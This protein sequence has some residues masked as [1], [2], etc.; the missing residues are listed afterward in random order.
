MT[1]HSIFALLLPLALPAAAAPPELDSLRQQYAKVV[2]EPHEKGLAELDAKFTTALDNAVTTAKQAGRLDDVLALQQDQ[3]RIADKLPLPDDE[4]TTPEVVK[5]LRVIYREQSAKL[6]ARREAAHAEVLPAYVAKLQELEATLTK[7]DRV[8]DALQVKLHRESLA[9]GLAPV[10][11]PP[12]AA[13]TTTPAPVAPSL[14]VPK[15]KGDDRK[16]AE[17]V[18]SVGGGV[19][20]WES[21]S[22]SRVITT[23]ADLPTGKLSLRVVRL[24]NIKGGIQPVSDADLLVLAGLE[25]LERVVWVKLPITPAAFDVLST[26]PQLADIQ[27]QYNR[28]GDELWTHLAGVGKLK[29]FWQNYDGLPVQGIG[30]S[31]LGREVESLN[32]SSTAV[33]DAALV[34]IGG[35]AGMKQLYLAETKITDAGLPALAQLKNLHMLHVMDTDVTAAGL[36]SLKGLP[37]VTLGYGRHMD[38]LAAQVP[39][40]AAL[41]PKLEQ[42]VVPRDSNPT[43]EHWNAVAAALPRLKAIYLRSFKFSDSASEGL[44]LLPDLEKLD[45]MYAPL[46]DV[47]VAHLALLEK[48]NWLSIPDAKI[49]DA[50]LDTI[51]TMKKLKLVN[52]PEPNG[53]PPAAGTA[54]LK[55]NRTDLVVN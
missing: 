8:P 29:K 12:M 49:T 21:S 9:A 50:A 44:G 34:E 54:A 53:P 2:A 33:V 22:A 5:N 16:A 11:G 55:P 45:L 3:K 52:L 39:T 10:S 17:W 4:E 15:S 32:L 47:G 1:I 23:L 30:I 37:L 38:D 31:R 6:A 51:A 35:F 13:M 20:I 28:L 40:V 41:F 43:T 7:A 46:T 27:L 24:D 19:E 42:L 48:L 36:A 26:C 18:L 25:R 14:T